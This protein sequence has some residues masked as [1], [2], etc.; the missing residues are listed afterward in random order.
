MTRLKDI[1]GKRY[2]RWTV[3]HVLPREEGQQNL[4]WRC[5]CDCGTS[6]DITGNS[7]KTGISSSCGCLRTE[8]L[9][10]RNIIHGQSDTPEYN[11]WASMLRRCN[12]V[13]HKC[14]EHYGGRGITVCKEWH[15]FEQFL[16]DMGNRPKGYSLDRINNDGNYNKENCRWATSTEQSSNTSRSLFFTINGVTKPIKEWAKSAGISATTLSYRIKAGWSIKQA[17]TA[18]KH[19]RK[20]TK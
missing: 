17:C 8:L 12:D 5:I 9:A 20:E 13:S 10:R 7:L 19:T 2:G 15:S 16:L 4:K 11:S 14:F 3:Q 18:P 1:S 6:G